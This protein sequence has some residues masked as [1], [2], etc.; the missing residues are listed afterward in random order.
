MLEAG[1][2]VQGAHVDGAGQQGGHALGRAVIGH[3]GEL[4]AHFLGEQQP[5]EVAG[6]AEGG[7]DLDRAR[8]LL[9]VGFEFFEG[10]EGCVRYW[11][12]RCRAWRSGWRRS[13]SRQ[14]GS[15]CGHSRKLV[16]ADW[17]MANRVQ[18]SGC[19]LGG[20]LRPLVAALS[21]HGHH[22][23]LR[24]DVQSPGWFSRTRRRS[25][26]CRR[27]RPRARSA[28]RYRKGCRR[29]WKVRCAE[30]SKR[31]CGRQRLT[32]QEVRHRQSPLSDGRIPALAGRWF[33]PI[34]GPAIAFFSAKL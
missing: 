19:C 2:D 8:V 15:R 28:G 26:G 24:C 18:P 27:L 32:L 30:K 31:R 9:G 6:G 14:N 4:D 20:V 17:W 11:R 3:V 33:Q 7:A 13:R 23:D 25:R 21:G 10:V 1:G 16:T 12:R 5:E 34:G 22:L 29:L